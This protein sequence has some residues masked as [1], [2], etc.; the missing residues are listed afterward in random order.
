[1]CMYVAESPVGAVSMQ[2]DDDT[3]PVAR[4]RY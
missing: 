3:W 4:I 1:M 2:A